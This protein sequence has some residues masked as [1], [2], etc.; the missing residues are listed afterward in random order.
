MTFLVEP[1][2][3][4]DRPA[5]RP[6]RGRPHVA[7]P[8]REE[9]P[10]QRGRLRALQRVEELRL[11]HLLARAILL[12]RAHEVLRIDP[13]ARVNPDDADV[14][15][16]DAEQ[17]GRLGDRVVALLRHVQPQRP[18]ERLDAKGL[19]RSRLVSAPDGTER[20]R[21]VYAIDHAKLAG[22]PASAQVVAPASAQVVA[23]ASAQV[24]HNHPQGRGRY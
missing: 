6:R 14:V 20:R 22:A 18:L 4:G 1:V 7:D 5:Q 23:P 24:E 12:D 16:S 19:V 15:A 2:V 8:E 3:H 9:E 11:D 17:P 10:A 13:Q 21:K